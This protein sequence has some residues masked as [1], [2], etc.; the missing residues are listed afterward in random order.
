MRSLCGFGHICWLVEQQRR[1]YHFLLLW[2]LQSQNETCSNLFLLLCEQQVS[3]FTSK[4]LQFISCSRT[5]GTI[6]LV[7]SNWLWRT[8]LLTMA[9]RKGWWALPPWGPL[10]YYFLS[11]PFVQ[12]YALKAE[13]GMETVKEIPCELRGCS[14]LADCQ[15]KHLFHR[16]RF[17]VWESPPPV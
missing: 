16:Y 5:N 14:G 8:Q 2:A 17:S 6:Q 7:G 4:Q 9:F 15:R 1:Y 13:I 10:F 12:R 3:S 11:C